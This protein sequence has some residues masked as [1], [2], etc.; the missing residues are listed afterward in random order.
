MEDN[1]YCPRC[2]SETIRCGAPNKQEQAICT[3][4]SCDWSGPWYIVEPEEETESAI[5][6]AGGKP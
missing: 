5:T 3:N 4:P 6:K 2:D 1:R